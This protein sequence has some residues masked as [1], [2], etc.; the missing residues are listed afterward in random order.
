MRRRR[1]ATIRVCCC[2]LGPDKMKPRMHKTVFT[3]NLINHNTMAM[4]MR[5]H[6]H[7]RCISS[8]SACDF[9]MRTV[10]MM[11]SASRARGDHREHAHRLERRLPN[12]VINDNHHH[13]TEPSVCVCVFAARVHCVH[14]YAV[15]ACCTESQLL[16]MNTPSHTVKQ[17]H[18]PAYPHALCPMHLP[19]IDCAA[20][21]AIRQV[22]VSN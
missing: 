4:V 18:K 20:A 13:A 16:M 9:E 3:N 15:P 2:I 21:D 1:R 10:D 8:G 22:I 7:T 14:N 6:T 19:S 11:Q 5:R 17:S 12:R